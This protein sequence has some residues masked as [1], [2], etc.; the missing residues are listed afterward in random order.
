MSLEEDQ[1]R[2][3]SLDRPSLILLAATIVM[4]G[5]DAWVVATIPYRAPVSSVVRESLFILA[6]IGVGAVA[7]W[8]R[9][10][11]LARRILAFA[12]VLAADLAGSFRLVSDDVLVRL[13]YVL[14]AV[15][16][17]LQI[18]FAGH[19]LLSY[20]SGRLP[21]PMARRLVAA[22]YVVGGLQGLWQWLTFVRTTDCASCVRP[23]EWIEVSEALERAVSNTFFGVWA[24]LAGCFI[25]ALV[26]RYRR[27]GRRERGL[28]RLPYLSII[29][30][31]VMFGG[32]SIVAAVQGA[33]SV[34]TMSTEALV[35]FQIVVLLG[36][37]LC[38]LISLLHERLA[39]RPI[40]ELVVK[41]AGGADADLERSLSVALRDPQLTIAFP[42]DDGFVDARGQRVPRPEAD[43]RTTVT[44]V[45][46]GDGHMPMALIRHDRSLD[47]EPALLTAAGSAT[48]LILENARLQ[49]EVR[50][51]LIQV[52]DSRARI[53]SATNAARVQLERD[54]HDGAQQR[55]LAIGIALQ[56]IRQQPG[57]P[58]L[59][60]AAE[61][62][63][64]S[65]LAELRDL[66]AGIH[67]AVLTD[68]GLV[69]AFEELV[70]RLGD[71]VRLDVVPEVRR[72][73]SGIEAAA[74]F[75]TS[76]AITNALKH[77]GPSSVAVTVAH[78][79][80][81]LMIRVSDDGP[82]GADPSGSGLLGIRDRLAAVDG[83]LSVVSPLGR[84][85]QLT[86][87]LPCA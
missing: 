2:Q 49:A 80:D 71:R 5:I 78:S 13:P 48:R 16:V 6:W 44:P 37:P 66:A 46:D 53:V 77:A 22:A 10:A 43:E 76:E 41:L 39:Y 17:P 42:I 30:S 84:G 45:N 7:L 11:L 74:Y 79:D 33:R 85:T 61:S 38:F 68:L 58:A 54:L 14:V 47:D 63:L 25:A 56:L 9:R 51:Q 87:E 36:V 62:E 81:W 1:N 55:L 27:A 19:L 52:R 72:C 65:A 21:D 3:T 64:G 60:D 23:L 29:L 8:L 67:P 73:S 40:G 75:A 86:M 34:W 31:A 18:A 35:A 24:L 83:A 12:L 28:L 15:L 32:L 50:A 26:G 82:G 4:L 69:P 70:A 20:P 57:D 59:L